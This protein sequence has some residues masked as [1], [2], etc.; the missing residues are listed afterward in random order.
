MGLV[1]KMMVPI[2]MMLL[3]YGYMMGGDKV[4]NFMDNMP[5]AK[6]KGVEGISSAVTDEEVT[7]YQWVDE[8]G[9]KHYSNSKPV[10]KSVDELKMSPKANVI[11]AVKPQVV[12]EEPKTGGK[13]TSITA[14]PYSPGG[15]REMIDKTKGLKDM[16]NQR[17][18]DQQSMLDQIS[19]K[20]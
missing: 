19:G 11:Q 20:K 4:L 12:V 14:S 9:V 5:Q 15:A 1:F 16:M 17:A 10:G 13:V 7:V 3:I 2:I 6:P 8:K 18:E